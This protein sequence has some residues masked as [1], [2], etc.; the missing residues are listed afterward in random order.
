[1]HA[2]LTV[3]VDITGLVSQ[4]YAQHALLDAQPARNLVQSF[5]AHFALRW[6]ESNI[7]CSQEFV[8]PFVLHFPLGA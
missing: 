6:L 5:L 2:L 4:V 8:N 7:I 1:M 3:A